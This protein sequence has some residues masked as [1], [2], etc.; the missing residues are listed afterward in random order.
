[1]TLAHFIAQ[2]GDRGGGKKKKEGQKRW[3]TCTTQT[4]EIRK[5]N[6]LRYSPLPPLSFA[7][8]VICGDLQAFFDLKTFTVEFHKR[9]VPQG[10]EA[11]HSIRH[12]SERVSST[13]VN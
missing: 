8:A 4:Q 2:N 7:A 10:A 3:S 12:I 11:L 6:L 1:M 5:I 9:F 13:G